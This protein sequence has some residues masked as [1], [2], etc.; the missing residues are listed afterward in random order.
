MNGA[1][2]LELRPEALVD[3]REAHE[4]YDARSA[5]AA[6]RFVNEVERVLLLI[7]SEPEAGGEHGDGTRR[8]KLRG[9]PFLII[10]ELMPDRIV[11]WAI[12]HT[13][14]NPRSWQEGRE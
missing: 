14:R 9:F 6:A 3:L 4:W 10:Y 2:P 1:L 8:Y 12:F 5:R 11:V 7:E 13:R